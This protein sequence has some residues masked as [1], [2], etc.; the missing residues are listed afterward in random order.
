[1]AVHFLP[2]QTDD[3]PLRF[4]IRVS[5][6]IVRDNDWTALHGLLYDELIANYVQL[7][8]N[9]RDIAAHREQMIRCPSYPDEEHYLYYGSADVDKVTQEYEDVHRI[10]KAIDPSRIV[11]FAMCQLFELY[12][13]DKVLD[14]QAIKKVNYNVKIAD[15]VNGSG[16]RRLCAQ[17]LPSHWTDNMRLNQEQ[18]HFMNCFIVFKKPQA[19]RENV[20]DE[21]DEDEN[22]LKKDVN[23]AKEIPYEPF[24]Y[25]RLKFHKGLIATFDEPDEA[26]CEEY[27]R[28]QAKCV[29]ESSVRDTITKYQMEEMEI[30]YCRSLSMEGYALDRISKWNKVMHGS[31]SSNHNNTN[32][33]KPKPEHTMV[34]VFSLRMHQIYCA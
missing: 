27:L 29:V 2:K 12:Q 7:Q 1:M 21:Y 25:P 24:S 33:T 30:R 31:D 28:K 26:Q 15:Y 9:E 18:A 20:K 22:R 14:L 23:E 11:P 10:P 13:E 6:E 32:S 16:H 5:D 4:G 19:V 3:A 8:G 34:I 17:Q